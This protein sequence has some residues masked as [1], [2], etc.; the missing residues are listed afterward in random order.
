MRF[1]Y[2]YTIFNGIWSGLGESDSTFRGNVVRFFLFGSYQMGRMGRMGIMGS[3]GLRWVPTTECRFLK[4]IDCK[5]LN[6]GIKL[7]SG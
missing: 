6:K 7:D 4:K 3:D 1:T 2:F 5:V